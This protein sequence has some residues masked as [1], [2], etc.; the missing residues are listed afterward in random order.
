MFHNK[1]LHITCLCSDTHDAAFF[2]ELKIAVEI[3]RKGLVQ[4][5]CYRYFTISVLR[6]LI[7]EARF[8]DQSQALMIGQRVTNR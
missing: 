2:L 1:I 6:Q 4:L 7:V 3:L 8:I 5:L